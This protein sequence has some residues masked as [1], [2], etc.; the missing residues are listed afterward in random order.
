MYDM[1]D[2]LDQLRMFWFDEAY[3]GE[4]KSRIPVWW[5]RLDIRKCNE[6]RRR[7]LFA[8]NTLDQRCGTFSDIKDLLALVIL[9]NRIPR[10]IFQGTDLAYAYDDQLLPLVRNSLGGLDGL[11]LPERLTFLFPLVCSRSLD[12]Q[13]QFRDA[14][15][16][17]SI[18][19]I[20]APGAALVAVLCEI[21]QVCENHIHRH[22]AFPWR[23]TTGSG[24]V[25]NGKKDLYGISRRDTFWL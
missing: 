20:D 21:S 12:D 10:L 23:K 24:G 18:T 14:L 22:E 19:R 9:F 11:T 25:A 1:Y 4:E 8:L 6:A 17:Y 5:F 15:N 2:T 3:T 7:F 13:S 16:A